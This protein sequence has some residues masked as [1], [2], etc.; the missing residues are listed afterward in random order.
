MF[1]DPTL[2]L[3]CMVWRDTIRYWR[4]R[5]SF[6]L[7]IPLLSPSI[8]ADSLEVLGEEIAGLIPITLQLP[9]AVK[10]NMVLPAVLGNTA[11]GIMNPGC[12]QVYY[13]AL[14]NWCHNQPESH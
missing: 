13:S 11:K 2:R 12:S 8:G 14:L 5:R 1:L 7:F 6:P 10:V 9:T 4:R 3:A